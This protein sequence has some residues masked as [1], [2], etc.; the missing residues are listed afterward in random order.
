MMYTVETQVAST[1]TVH[2]LLHVL[3]KGGRGERSVGGCRGQGAGNGG[4]RSSAAHVVTVV[5][6]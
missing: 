2:S 4:Q 6:A 1:H 5:V 3:P